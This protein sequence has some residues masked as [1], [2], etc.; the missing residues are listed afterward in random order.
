MKL[1]DYLPEVPAMAQQMSELNSQI[2]TLELMKASGDTASSPSF[3]LDHVVNTWVRHQMAYRQ[4]LVMDIQTISMSVE[5]VRSPVSHIT[6][7]VFRRGIE[8][9]A[10]VQDPDP[11]QR[12]RM[13]KV[14]SSCNVFDQS[15][16]EVLRQFHFDVNIVDDGFLYLVKEFYDDGKTVRSKVKEIRRLNPALVEFDLDMAGLPKNAHFVCPLHREEI[17]DT[18]GTCK[19]S[20]C[21]RERWP[22]MYKYY[23]RSQH[24]Y[25][26]E[27]EVIHVSKFFPSETYGWS[28]LLTIF[29]KVLTL[30]GMDKNLYRYFFERKMPGSM[31]MVFTDDPESLRRERANIAAQ[32]RIDPNFVPMVAVSAKNNRGR[33]DMVRLFHTLQEMDYLPVRAEIRE[34]VAA[35]WGVTPAWQGAP[36]A[37]GGLSTQTQ[38]LVVMSRVVEGDQRIFHEKIFPQLLDAFGITDWELILPQPEE[39]AESTRIQ[40]AQQKIAIA[41]QY[42]NMG[43]DVVIKDQ[44]VP[45]EEVEFIIGGQMVPS[46]KMQGE[47]QALQLEQQQQQLEQGEAQAQG[48]GNFV[49]GGEE[50]LPPEE[51]EEEEG[52]MESI[53]AMLMKT[54]P[55][56]KRK[57][58]GRTGG[59]TPDWQDKLPH[60]ERDIDEYADARAAKNT[61]TLMQDSQTWVE[62]L[63]QKGFNMPFIKQVS[64]DGKQMWFAQDSV[65][66]V[67]QLNGSGVVHIE[68][69]KVDPGV[70]PQ[71]P[72]HPGYKNYSSY[73]PTGNHREN[74]DVLREDEED[75]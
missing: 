38:Q 2:N 41:N 9:K 36:E 59:R 15:L 50:E 63:I 74:P 51:G 11:E 62:S 71:S 24:I 1:S 23:H 68:K 12:E 21:E 33:V 31:M 48:E 67:A 44:D 53:Q 29:E 65:D 5:E 25:L 70:H 72:H 57:F 8:W 30:I 7:E 20:S 18:P 35:M 52:G 13:E 40:F 75:L 32:T 56:H 61:L 58:K 22:I 43:F 47:Q 4:Q 45:M 16:E 55:K 69:A 17:S 64:P 19:E 54:I 34:R 27:S 42:A 46:A 66:Y 10:K 6:G 3:G 60:E 73:N 14:L 49:E 26:F 28:P 37:F 39:R